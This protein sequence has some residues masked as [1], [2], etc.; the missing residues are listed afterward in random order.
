MC[1]TSCNQKQ[2]TIAK[3]AIFTIG[4]KESAYYYSYGIIFYPG[5]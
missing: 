4:S 2:H 5:V 3:E 1:P